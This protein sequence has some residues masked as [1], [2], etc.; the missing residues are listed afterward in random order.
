MENIRTLRTTF[1]TN[2]D[3]MCAGLGTLISNPYLSPC[4][5]MSTIKGTV[6]DAK[7]PGVGPWL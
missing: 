4:V 3:A 5:E 1:E 2:I 7:R 6:C